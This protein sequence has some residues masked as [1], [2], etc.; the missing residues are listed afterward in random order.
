[1]ARIEGADAVGDACKIIGSHVAPSPSE[2]ISKVASPGGTQS[3][4]AEVS[5]LARRRI[6]PVGVTKTKTV[7]G[8]TPKKLTGLCLNFRSDSVFP[9]D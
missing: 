3:L 6:T 1:M 4:R 8:L 5:Q 2:S 9:F 7:V